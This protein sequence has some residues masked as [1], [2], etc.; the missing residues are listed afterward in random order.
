MRIAVA[1]LL[2]AGA[3]L[4]KPGQASAIPLSFHDHAAA[5]RALSGAV[6]EAG[7]RSAVTKRQARRYSRRYGWTNRPY[8]RPYQYR[9]WKY[10]YPYGGPLF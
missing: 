2:I 3:L 1:L 4:I 6:E 8:W 9:Y 5:S 7:R 10:Y